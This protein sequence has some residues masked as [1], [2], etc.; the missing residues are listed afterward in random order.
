MTVTFSDYDSAS[1]L[2]NDEEI[3]AYLE[4]VLEED[5]PALFNH[6]LGVIARARGMSAIAREAGLGR[7]ALYRALSVNGNPEFATI[8]R[9]LKVLGLR[10]A[11]RTITPAR[12]APAGAS[13]RKAR[14]AAKAASPAPRRKQ[15]TAQASRG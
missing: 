14:P 4:A 2:R 5:D 8:M 9:V 6:A 11:A 15:G 10:F 3:V 7:E 1:L 12:P 13:P